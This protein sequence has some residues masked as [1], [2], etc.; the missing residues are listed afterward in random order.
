MVEDF[1]AI[2]TG[3]DLFTARLD[4]L[5]KCGE[6]LEAIED[7]LQSCVGQLA[8]DLGWRRTLTCR[9][10]ALDLPKISVFPPRA[11]Q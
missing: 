8:H 9:L 11:H 4:A 1:T 10:A 3:I 2:R 6:D 7:T 5:V